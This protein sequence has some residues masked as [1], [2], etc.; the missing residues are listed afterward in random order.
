MRRSRN[1]GIDVATH[2][3]INLPSDISSDDNISSDNGTCGEVIIDRVGNNRCSHGELNG[4]SVDDTHNIS[5][6]GG[7]KN[8]EERAVEAILSV[9][10][11]NL[12]VIVGTLQE[13]NSCVKR[14]SISLQENLNTVDL[15]VEG[16]GTEG[17]SLNG[18][19]VGDGLGVRTVDTLGAD[20]GSQGELDLSDVTDSNGVGATGSLD[21]GVEG[22]EASVLNVHA[23]LARGVVGSLPQLDIGVK[24]TALGAQLDLKALDGGGAV[25]P[26]LEGST[27]NKDGLLS[28]GTAPS[29]NLSVGLGPGEST[30]ILGVFLCGNGRDGDH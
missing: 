14:T 10:L 16:V 17:S 15:R 6:S 22:T 28:D 25:G 23:H 9:K 11:N 24:G 7:L 19:G 12:L 20:A 21:H 26:G 2:A 27:L 3:N 5:A 18:H 30:G 1:S 8:S 4:G 29:G 13:L